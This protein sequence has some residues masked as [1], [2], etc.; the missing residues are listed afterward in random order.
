VVR[1][2]ASLALAALIVIARLAS[3]AD[4]AIAASSTD[5]AIGRVNAHVPRATKR[6][7]HSPL[8]DSERIVPRRTT[9]GA[10]LATAAFALGGP[11]RVIA[12]PT[13]ASLLAPV[14][15][16]APPIASAR[17]PPA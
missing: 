9:L 17:A 7:G 4:S 5:R 14:D 13:H 11:S 10:W 12:L 16:L 2:H 8:L 3:G 15:A 1:R 6:S